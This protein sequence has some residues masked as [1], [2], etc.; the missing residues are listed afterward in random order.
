MNSFFSFYEGY[1]DMNSRTTNSFYGT[2]YNYNFIL[3]CCYFHPFVL[4]PTLQTVGSSIHSSI[5]KILLIVFS[6]MNAMHK[7]QNTLLH[8]SRIFSIIS[9]DHVTRIFKY[10]VQLINI[11][12]YMMQTTRT[13]YTPILYTIFFSF[14]QYIILS[15]YSVRITLIFYHRIKIEQQI[16]TLQDVGSS[17]HSN[18]QKIPLIVFSTMISMHKLQNTL[19]NSRIFFSFLQ[20]MLISNRLI[21]T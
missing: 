12:F 5:Q 17:I 20:R 8:H 11:D 7:P 2:R 3:V 18:I 9:L 13:K 4:L 16:P 15:L 14:T 10:Q 19:L 21:S 6:T 1:A